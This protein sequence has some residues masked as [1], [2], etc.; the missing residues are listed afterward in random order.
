[1]APSGV[2]AADVPRPGIRLYSGTIDGV[3]I[4][5]V[6]RHQHRIARCS[7]LDAVADVENHQAVVPPAPV[8]EAILYIHVVQAAPC[9]ASIGAR[10]LPRR[11]L[12]RLGR[13]IDVDHVDRAGAV[14]RDVDVAAVPRVGVDKG[15][16]HAR[17]DAVG[18]VGNF[19]GAERIFECG[20]DDTVLPVVGPFAREHHH[21][22]LFVGHDVIH[23]AEVLHDRVGDE[24]LRGVRNVDGVETIATR[25]RP[26]IRHLSIGMDP[27][28]R[29]DEGRA[30]HRTDHRRF[31]SDGTFGEIDRRVTGE[32]SEVGADQIGPGLVAH[33]GAV[34]PDLPLAGRKGPAWGEPVDHLARR[35]L[36]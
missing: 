36:H 35:I 7:S 13:V 21:L 30:Q 3:E 18:E 1:M 9:I 4:V 10:R 26:Q 20:D 14:I 6:L 17:R 24:G 28:L 27:D 12:A 29:R 23:D 19:P 8:Q 33:K 16:V 22:A 34:I 31:A 25:V 11:R 5:L 32:A 15:G 2:R